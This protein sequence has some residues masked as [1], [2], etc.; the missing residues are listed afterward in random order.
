MCLN[1]FCE[2]FRNHRNLLSFCDKKGEMY[3]HIGFVTELLKGEFVSSCG[4]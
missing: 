1:V 4:G 2:C 3:R